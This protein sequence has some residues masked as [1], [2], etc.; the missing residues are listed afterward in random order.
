VFLDSRASRLVQLADLIAYG[1]F[2]HFER[3]DS[4]FFEVFK[5]RFDADGGVVHGLYYY[6]R[7]GP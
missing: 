2:R 5:R 7:S 1:T 3:N 4:Q 6:N